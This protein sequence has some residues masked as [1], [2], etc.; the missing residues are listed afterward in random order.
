MDENQSQRDLIEFVNSPDTIP[1]I[2]RDG[3]VGSANFRHSHNIQSGTA[4]EGG[5]YVDYV[6]QSEID[7]IVNE[8]GSDELN[9]IP[10]V[11]GLLDQQSLEEAGILQV[12]R[13]PFLDLR[14]RGTL[15]GLIDT[16]IDYTND[17]F[18]YEDGTSKIKYIWD[19][20]ILGEPP[21][22]YYLGT[23]YS[24]EQINEALKAENPFE[25]VPHR[26]NV[27]HGTFLASLAAS[28]DRGEYIGAAPDAE[29]IAV[30][31]K[32]AEQ[33]FYDRFLIPQEQE[34]AYASSD[35]ILGIQYIANKADELGYPVAICLAVG[36]NLGGHDG[37]DVM[38]EYITR[39]SEVQGV[40]ITC[41]AGNEGQAA[42]H[43]TGRL[44]NTTETKD[45]ELIAGDRGND[46]YLSLWNGI[47]DRIAV[48]ITSPLGEIIP[49]IP[50]RAGASYTAN[51]VLER[52][53]V[54]VEY[55]LPVRTSGDQFTR[56]K[57]FN[58]TPG[59]WKI[60]LHGDIILDGTYH[61]WLPISGFIESGTVFLSPSP[62]NT[63]AVPATAFG[64]ITC[65][66]YD[67]RSNSLYTSTSWGPTR[68]LGFSPDF[69]APGVN[70]GGV[71][72]TGFG[73]MSGTSVS[74]AITTG[75][76]ALMLQ[77]GVV[78]ENETAMTTSRIRAHLIRGCTRTPLTESANVQWGYGKLNLYNS[79]N[80]IR[81]I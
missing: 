17:V 18:K 80:I 25:I 34:N 73:N 65:G 5:Y 24:N 31:L 13:L 3:T 76:C 7:G 43:A 35:I 19:Q 4:I 9:M 21:D 20:T 60:T 62:Y 32:R 41:A 12:Q 42:H 74:A 68:A 30:K 67:S 46:I 53:R 36:T 16:G 48:S 59:I 72:P 39:M 51:L 55:F 66:A 54:S 38:E 14:G 50:V 49:K 22:G 71:F 1:I 15:I 2:I 69:V 70:V 77:W 28:R 27:G 33:F 6:D 23:E 40:A 45:I 57:I 10:I 81:P 79:L 29:I 75:A 63:I 61:L 64:V 44:L 37:F 11:L 8:V 78:D 47:A 52:A 56:I 58:P 26:D